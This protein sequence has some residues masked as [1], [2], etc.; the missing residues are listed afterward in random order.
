[1]ENDLSI[2]G[3]PLDQLLPPPTE[4]VKRKEPDNVMDAEERLKAGMA[5]ALGPENVGFKMMMKMGFSPANNQVEPLKIELRR[6]KGGLGHFEELQVQEYES[7][8][9][10]LEL[11]AKRRKEYEDDMTR[12][13]QMRDLREAKK[14]IMAHLL[15]MIKVAR[16]L[17]D[18]H[19][20]EKRALTYHTSPEFDDPPPILEHE[21]V[22]A[23]QSDPTAIAGIRDLLSHLSLEVV[24]KHSK[25]LTEYLREDFWYCY[26]C[27]QA[28]ESK[29]AMDDGCPGP[30]ENDHLSH[31]SVT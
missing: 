2:D 27:G 1:M 3:V 17:R 11:E 12:K 8:Q 23:S 13:V 31:V 5:T 24:E 10:K 21:L 20:H 6:G 4:R 9:I 14:R 18:D 15:S 29:Q 30:T 22:L 19:L 7:E 16:N 26:W 28:F 25:Q